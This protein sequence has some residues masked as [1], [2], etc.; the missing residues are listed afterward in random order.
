M[1]K[2]THEE[3]IERVKKSYPTVIIDSYYEGMSK[4]IKCHCAVCGYA[5]ETTPNN[6]NKSKGCRQ[7]TLKRLR[8]SKIMSHEQFIKDVQK[9]NPNITVIGKYEGI[10][11]H[12]ECECNICSHKWSASAEHIREGCGCPKCASKNNGLNQRLSHES[13]VSE[14]KKKSPSIS[15]DSEYEG[16]S[17]RIKCHC[18]ICGHHW[19]PR[20][21]ELK[22]GNKC[23]E[24]AKESRRQKLIKSHEDFINRL[25]EINHNIKILSPYKMAKE[26][27]QCECLI[28]GNQWD[29][30]PA[31]LL[32]GRG[33]PECAKTNR[34]LKSRKKYDDFDAEVAKINPKIEVL[35]NYIKT[36][37]HVK[38]RCKEC[39]N[40]WNILPGNI[41]NGKGCPICK[42]VE[43]GL[44]CRS[45]HEEFLEKLSNVNNTVILL[46]QYET[47]IT[48]VKCQCKICGSEFEATP[49]S[50]LS[51]RKCPHCASSSA[52]IKTKTILDNWHINYEK[53]YRYDDLRGIGGRPLSYDFYLPDYNLLIE[54][55]GGQH[56]H[57]VEC[58]GGEK[59]FEIQQ[60]HDKRKR[61]YAKSHNIPLLEIW[62]WDFS[63]IEDILTRE[64]HLDEKEAV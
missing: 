12:I 36:T 26:K 2:I 31:K 10:K 60:E 27:V 23:P 17:N 46:S 56:D 20:A 45:T 64:L 18:L 58:F 3:Y 63:N 32:C 37:E 8:D 13:F 28:C 24:C 41:F 29:A 51:G 42:R 30:T 7:C 44:R 48:K 22:A 57:P 25:S 40:V 11:K 35:S 5:W 62:Y 16:L 15:I 59:Q 43:N 49:Q 47:S 52:E 39:G 21:G 33:C 50:L 55:Q 4:P 54:C 14:I 9:V 34:G 1:N 61:E 38:V 6:L 53:P 19:T